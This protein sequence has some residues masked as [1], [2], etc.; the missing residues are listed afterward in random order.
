M[1]EIQDGLNEHTVPGWKTKGFNWERA[2]WLESAEAVESTPWKWWAGC[3]NKLTVILRDKFV[4]SEGNLFDKDNMQ[5]ISN[6]RSDGYSTISQEYRKILPEDTTTLLHRLIWIYHNGEVPDS[7]EVDHKDV[8]PRN[9]N[10]GNLRLVTKKENQVNSD[11]VKNAK[12][13]TEKNGKFL[14]QI[15]ILGKKVHLGTFG[16]E[17]EASIAYQSAKQIHHVIED[18][19]PE[20]NVLKN[21]FDYQNILIELVDMW[22]FGLSLAVLEANF[23]V[24]FAE[25]DNIATL[26]AENLVT[27]DELKIYY[28]ERIAAVALTGGSALSILGAIAKAMNVFGMTRE[29]LIKIYLGK[30]TLN[31]FRQNNGYKSGTYIK[32]WN[33]QEDNVIMMKLIESLR[34]EDGFEDDLFELLEDEYANITAVQ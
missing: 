24:T 29:V 25:E 10:I 30:A 21:C 31:K 12:G 26:S 33:G 19:S 8:N 17:H 14:A 11:R 20:D 13:Y 23:D 5:K 1:M 22:H 15:R 32:M 4:Y 6:M 7:L 28:L 34:V 2:I 9:C 18:R 27:E 16:T 3:K